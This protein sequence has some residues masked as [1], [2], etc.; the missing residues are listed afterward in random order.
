MLAHQG[1]ERPTTAPVARLSHLRV[2]L[3][4]SGSLS[5][6]RFET[7]LAAL[8]EHD[9]VARG[10]EYIGRYTSRKTATA[11]IEYVAGREDVDRRFVAA[12]NG[13]E[14]LA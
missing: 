14:V 1:K 5:P 10:D 11:A 4:A 2:N 7:A 12:V 8:A 6:E 9:A 3:C 13:L